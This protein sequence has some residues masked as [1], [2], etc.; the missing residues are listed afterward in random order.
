[1]ATVLF[2]I[3]FGVTIVLVQRMRKN[4]TAEEGGPSA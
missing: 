3:S 1:M 2:V 4:S